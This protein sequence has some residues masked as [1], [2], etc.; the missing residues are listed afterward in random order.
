MCSIETPRTCTLL[1]GAL[2]EHLCYGYVCHRVWMLCSKRN[3]SFYFRRHSVKVSPTWTHTWVGLVMTAWVSVLVYAAH[4]FK[5]EPSV[6]QGSKDGGDATVTITRVTRWWSVNSGLTYCVHTFFVANYV[7]CC[8]VCSIAEGEGY[9]YCASWV[10]GVQWFR[11]S[12]L[13]ANLTLCD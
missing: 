1:N 9:V 12:T 4:G 8:I 2:W 13:T 11:H 3:K 5:C 7:N 6:G 10:W